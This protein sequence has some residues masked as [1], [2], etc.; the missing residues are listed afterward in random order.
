MRRAYHHLALRVRELVLA[1]S[2]NRRRLAADFADYH[3]TELYIARRHSV[4]PT[5][6]RPAST[7][8]HATTVPAEDFTARA[9]L[10][11]VYGSHLTRNS[12]VFAH[13]TP[14][15]VARLSA[16]FAYDRLLGARALLDLEHFH[17]KVVE[18]VL[19]AE[20]WRLFG[21]TF[22]RARR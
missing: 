12:A 10:G 15:R 8:L 11:G 18:S 4:C 3:F 2:N 20:G 21:F 1:F 5:E 7:L 19:V 17:V 13:S 16:R 6:L 22:R 14:A 9:S